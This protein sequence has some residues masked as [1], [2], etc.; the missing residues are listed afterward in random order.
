MVSF[1]PL[2]SRTLRKVGWNTTYQQAAVR[3]WKVESSSETLLRPAIFDPADLCKV[4]GVTS[5]STY[6]YQFDRLTRS[7]I[8]HPPVYAHL[9]RDVLMVKGSLFKW[10]MVHHLADRT[11]PKIVSDPRLEV[12]SAALASTYLGNRYFGHWLLDDLPLSLLA[13][14][15]GP[16]FGHLG[17]DN[18]ASEHQ[19]EYISLLE[20]S[21]RYVQSALFHELIIFD[22]IT[23]NPFKA[24]R[25]RDLRAQL[26]KPAAGSPNPGVMLL[27]GASGQR[28]LLVNEDEIACRVAARGF[29]VIDPM[30]NKLSDII[31]ASQNARVLIG[32]EGSQLAHA[33]LPMDPGG[34]IFTLQPPFKFDNFW[35]DRSACMGGNYALLVGD[36]VDGGFQIDLDRLD[37]MLDEML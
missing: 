22:Y 31:I 24:A 26:R 21:V 18:H 5:G 23:E 27:R 20:P 14:E 1:T 16:L 28:R 2:I 4:T 36:Q 25:Y 29:R 12:K 15:Y 34:A 3:S 9:L 30:T 35:R 7:V 8:Q 13:S 17:F 10:N 11:M 37:R 32:N 19:A 33:F 6:D